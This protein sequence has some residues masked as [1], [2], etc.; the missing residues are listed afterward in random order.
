MFLEKSNGQSRKYVS[1]DVCR[2]RKFTSLHWVHTEL[3]TAVCDR[4]CGGYER[5]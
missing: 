2:R 4:C 5:L 1:I 3:T